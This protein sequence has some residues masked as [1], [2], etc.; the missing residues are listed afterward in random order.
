MLPTHFDFN[1]ALR[2]STLGKAKTDNVVKDGFSRRNNLNK[3]LPTKV[4]FLSVLFIREDCTSI[5]V[6][7]VDSS[8]E[9]IVTSGL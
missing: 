7:T 2:N 5:N 8:S 1:N 4:A 9:Y 3:S 6:I